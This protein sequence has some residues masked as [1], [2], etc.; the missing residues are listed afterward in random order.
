MQIIQYLSSFSLHFC[1]NSPQALF[2]KAN[3]YT[4]DLTFELASPT[5]LVDWTKAVVL[6]SELASG[7]P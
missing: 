2:M 6:C 1:E 4:V 5:S 7:L 3:K